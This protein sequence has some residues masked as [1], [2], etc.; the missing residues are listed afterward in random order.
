MTPAISKDE[1]KERIRLLARELGFADVGFAR[2]H[3]LTDSVEEN[4]FL[5]A[6]RLGH[7]GRME[8]LSRNFDKRMDPSLLLEG[9]KS[10]IVFLVP[11]SSAI[12][13]DNP[14][15]SGHSRLKISQYAYGTDYHTVIK[16]KL[17]KVAE[18]LKNEA[19]AKSRVFTDSAPVMERAWGVRAGVGFI[20]KNN[21]L[22]SP[23]VGIKNFIGII[24]TTAEL[25]QSETL[26]PSAGCGSCTKCLEA[27]SQKALYAPNKIDAS[28]CLSYK[29]IEEPLPAEPDSSSM[30]KTS[31][32]EKCAA[33]KWIFGCDDCMNACPWNKFNRPGW[34][35]FQT[36][37]KL[38]ENSTE[39]FWRNMSEEEFNSLFKDSPLKRA[40]LKKIKYNLSR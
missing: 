36:N 22:I 12:D 19:G 20:G 29:T 39:E 15:H 5:E 1:L 23:K 21:F 31:G 11:F 27:C 16:N 9:A 13:S 6:E 24:I 38:L 8:Y 35:E 18:L 30:P 28:K 14:N 2:V 37:R 17:Y 10:V 3:S 4:R 7:F 32:G 26:S 34:E 33:E 25:P 40:G